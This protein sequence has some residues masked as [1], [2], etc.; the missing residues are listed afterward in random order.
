MKKSD[1]I[2][3]TKKGYTWL[4]VFLAGLLAIAVIAMVAYSG[5]SL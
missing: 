4:D 5:V 2:K 3:G 1:F